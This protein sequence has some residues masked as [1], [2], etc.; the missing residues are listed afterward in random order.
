MGAAIVRSATAV[1]VV[2]LHAIVAHIAWRPGGRNLVKKTRGTALMSLPIPQNGW[3]FFIDPPT[4][5][6]HISPRRRDRTSFGQSEGKP[7]GTCHSVEENKQTD[8]CLFDKQKLIH[9]WPF[10][11]VHTFAW[12]EIVLGVILRTS[13]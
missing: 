1:N 6:D 5:V 12:D 4:T 8:N 2:G 7:P 11:D 3:T 10:G 13:G 9:N